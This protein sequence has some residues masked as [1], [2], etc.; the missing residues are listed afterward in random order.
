LEDASAPAQRHL[1]L[2]RDEARRLGR[3]VD[4]ALRLLAAEQGTSRLHL[5]RCRPSSVVDA[6]IEQFRPALA[7]R[8]VA[9]QRSGGTEAIAELDPE[10]LAQIVANLLSNV[11]KYA[12]GAPVAIAERW[13]ESHF[14]LSVADH[15]PGIP[16]AESDRIF[17]DWY[18]VSN[19]VAE[20]ATGIGLGLGIARDLARRLGGDLCLAP[21]EH[22]AAFLLRLPTTP[23]KQESARC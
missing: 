9:V 3:L 12:P 19:R 2:I 21:S 17:R 1:A 11:E 16:V 6:V 5:Q 14:E 7:R 23:S 22:G 15:G 18:R 10:A 8:G 20:G 4:N 13:T